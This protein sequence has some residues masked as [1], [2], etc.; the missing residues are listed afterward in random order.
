MASAS[1]GLFG[2]IEN[3]I[4]RFGVDP[5]S[6]LKSFDFKTIGFVGAGILLAVL[7]VDLLGYLYAAYQG[8]SRSYVPY[9]SKLAL[10]AADAWDNRHENAI[11]DYYDPYAR[12][13]SLEP[14]T[15]VLDSLSEAV[16]KWADVPATEA[17]LAVA[18]DRSF[19]FSRR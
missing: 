18:R 9:T 11:G 10:F 15:G 3:G 2:H 14:L 17:P 19:V 12:A 8:T 6:A 7:V 5:L 4:R 13:R 1:T 16:K